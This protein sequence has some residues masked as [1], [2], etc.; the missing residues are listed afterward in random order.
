MT[1]EFSVMLILLEI[2]GHICSYN[3][4]KDEC[5]KNKL[6]TS[7]KK[8]YLYF[9]SKDIAVALRRRISHSSRE[10]VVKIH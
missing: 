2:L 3:A 7:N 6:K 4:E 10:F 5:H 1:S 8:I 9:S